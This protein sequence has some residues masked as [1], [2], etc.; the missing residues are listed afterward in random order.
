MKKFVKMISIILCAALSA[1]ML[2]ACSDAG[3]PSHDVS[4][5]DYVIS[6]S[7]I[8]QKL[9]D[10]MEGREDRTMFSDRER[11]VSKYL[12]DELDA[13]GYLAEINEFNIVD[14]KS[15]NLKS[16]NVI[17]KYAGEGEARKNVII[18]AYYDNCNAKIVNVD[19]GTKNGTGTH[20]AL[21]NGT[22]V[23]T[24]LAVA[25]YL[26]TE[27]PSLDFDV[28]IAFF[29]AS[30]VYDYGATHYYGEMTEAERGNTVL[31]VE[32]QRLGVDHVYAYSDTRK[33]E[34]EELF[35]RVARENGLDIYKVTQKSPIITDGHALNG[36]PF[37]QWAHTGVYDVY[38][39]NG[40]PTLNLVGA[41][42]ETIDMSDRE[43]ANN[44]D[45]AF[46][47]NDTLQN[48]KAM[49]PDYADKL[50]TAATLIIDSLTD[51]QFLPVMIADK[52]N[53]PN[54]DLLAKR[55]VWNLIALGVIAV[56]A[57]VMSGICV[58]LAKKYVYVPPAPKQ[59]KQMQVAVFGL[60]YEDKD[61]N[62]V[63]IDVKRVGTPDDEIFPGIPN[64]GKNDKKPP[65]DD[66]FA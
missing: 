62:K 55:W 57:A 54:T 3:A 19:S 4:S 38:F 49:Y 17:A 6:P 30:S 40:I 20:G 5:P 35:D 13:Y 33:T 48:F 61:P 56:A 10:F 21:A 15:N 66:P 22:G 64:N 39:N 41:N 43:S 58:H 25:E 2:T 12:R 34:R 7:A 18:G 47:S 23:A 14:S 42:W 50:A 27:K 28:T 11:D 26:N 63:Y 37:Y 52:N 31:M 44:R 16:Q 29:G 46:T 45:I 36:I 53:F 65:S 60:D 8:A 9:D 51:E 32:L 1:I 24:L 59:A